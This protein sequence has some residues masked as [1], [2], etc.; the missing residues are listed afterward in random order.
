GC[1]GTREQGRFRGTG[2]RSTQELGEIVL[3]FEKAIR[4]SADQVIT[5]SGIVI[6]ASRSVAGA[7]ALIPEG[8]VGTDPDMRGS[9]SG[10]VD[11]GHSALGKDAR[12]RYHCD[13]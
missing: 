10:T 6:S 3:R 8:G 5:V 11:E 13:C 9:T 1:S 4:A 7:I 2:A 12:G